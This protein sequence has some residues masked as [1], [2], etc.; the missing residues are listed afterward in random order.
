MGEPRRLP[1]S[2]G[3]A[4][5]VLATAE[6]LVG[7]AEALFDRSGRLL[8]PDLVVEMLTPQAQLRD[9]T[10]GLG[11]RLTPTGP[12]WHSGGTLGHTAML[13]AIAGSGVVSVVADGPGAGPIAA[14]VGT[15]LF[16]AGPPAAPTA[17]E[18]G[19]PPTVYAGVYA[20][21]HITHHVDYADGRLTVQQVHHGP[22]A[23]LIPNPPPVVLTP[24][25]LDRFVARATIASGEAVVPFD[26]SDP[27]DS[28]RPTR[29]LTE[30]HHRRVN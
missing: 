22:V 2:V 21:R 27:D 1:R 9:G 13:W 5:N 24:V 26:F 28:G 29:L 6:D 11:W 30:H 18:P 25:A 14:S 12:A 15:Q 7:F 10:Q 3:P 16:G 8:A 4:G 19:R 17:N 23:Q 20:R